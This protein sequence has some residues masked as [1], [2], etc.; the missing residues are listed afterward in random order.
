VRRVWRKA[1]EFVDFAEEEPMLEN[2]EPTLEDALDEWAEQIA[3]Q[4]RAQGEAQGRAKGRAQGRAEG[5]AKGRDEG[6]AEGERLGEA[7]LLLR[8]LT[9]KFGP[10][11]EATRA[12][13]AAARSEDLFAWGERL[14]GAGRLADVFAG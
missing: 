10:L 5:R 14:L 9:F 2:A 7:Q 11:D 3:A 6:R 12:R 4:G 1:P 13:V 8:Q